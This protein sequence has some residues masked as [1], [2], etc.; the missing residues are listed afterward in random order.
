[1]TEKL[2]CESDI[3]SK[4]ESEFLEDSLKAVRELVPQEKTELTED[5]LY[6]DSCGDDLD[7][8]RARLG[9][10]TCLSC[11]QFFEKQNKQYR[12][13]SRYDYDD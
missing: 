1:M 3:A 10:S 12:K 2:T 9:Y 13:S 8:R 5:D 4:I 6:C 7:P 11:A